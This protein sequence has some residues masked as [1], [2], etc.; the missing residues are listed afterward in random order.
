MQVA[1]SIVVNCHRNSKPPQ[2][3]KTGSLGSILLETF[4]LHPKLQNIIKKVKNGINV[5]F[6]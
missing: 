3:F 4:R 2:A 1:F 5:V 6:R